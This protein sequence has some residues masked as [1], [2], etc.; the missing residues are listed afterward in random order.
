MKDCI[1]CKIAH[2]EVHS[3]VIYE[4]DKVFA[5]LDNSP[6]TPGHTLLIPKAHYEWFQDI[7]DDIS[8]DLFRIAKKLARE[9]KETMNADYIRLGIVGTDIPHTHIHLVPSKFGHKVHID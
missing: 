6:K 5:F 2:G 7:P 1:F 9:L 3:E 8:D 4:D